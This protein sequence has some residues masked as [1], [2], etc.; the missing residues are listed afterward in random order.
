MDSTVKTEMPHLEVNDQIAGRKLG[1]VD[2]RI[3]KYPISP[4][5]KK[6]LLQ[7]FHSKGVA[8]NLKGTWVRFDP[9]GVEEI[10][11]Y[12]AQQLMKLPVD[13]EKYI[14]NVNEN[15]VPRMTEVFSRAL[16]HGK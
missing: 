9:E 3:E 7:A 14:L 2:L 5:K 4:E 12:E 8:A 10:E 6:A 11:A 1:L 16:G 15:N 13:W